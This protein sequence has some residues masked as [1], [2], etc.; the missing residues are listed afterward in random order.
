MASRPSSSRWSPELGSQ[1]LVLV[2]AA[3]D[4]VEAGRPERL[5]GDVE[6][7]HRAELLGGVHSG[8][9]EQLGVPRAELVGILSVLAR[10]IQT[11]NSLVRLESFKLMITIIERFRTLLIEGPRRYRWSDAFLDEIS[12]AMAQSLPDFQIILA[13]RI[14]LGGTSS[15]KRNAILT[16]FLFRVI[17]CYIMAMPNLVKKSSFDW[18]KLLP[19]TA[20][21]FNTSLPIVQMRMLN[22]LKKIVDSGDHDFIQQFMS[23]RILF[24]ILLSTR[25]EKV[26]NYCHRIALKLLRHALAVNTS[27][28]EILSSV[29]YEASVWIGSLTLSTLPALFK[30]LEDTL[31]DSWKQIAFVGRAW[32]THN[33]PK[34][35][36]FSTLLS[37]ALSSQTDSKDFVMMVCQVVTRCLLYSRDPISLAAVIVYSNESN[38]SNHSVAENTH[39]IPLIEYAQKLLHLNDENHLT[40]ISCLRKLLHAYF[41]DEALLSRAL[42]VL[43]TS[44]STLLVDCNIS[45]DMNHLGHAD[46]I[47]LVNFLNHYVIV[48]SGEKKILKQ[49]WSIIGRIIPNI[50]TVSV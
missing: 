3:A 12:A 43:R 11:E 50:I 40:V 7:E 28:D 22:C 19:D 8:T 48:A 5:V 35:L 41:P 15:G 20:D 14:R 27:N 1:P 16:D 21:L 25:S 38:E 29:Q 18:M 31:Q 23:S 36:Q 33:A 10:S 2:D 32:N 24:E 13:M 47:S 17:E 49:Y 9:R 42:D 6:P 26:H 4:D 30:L 45:S 39:S 37:A 46:Q 44:E 34:K